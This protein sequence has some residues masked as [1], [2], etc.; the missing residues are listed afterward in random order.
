METPSTEYPI[1]YGC[2]DIPVMD[3]RTSRNA[4]LNIGQFDSSSQKKPLGF[5]S[6]PV[7]PAQLNRSISATVPVQW[8]HEI[9]PP[10]PPGPPPM[11]EPDIPP[12]LET[13]GFVGKSI[14]QK[15]EFRKNVIKG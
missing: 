5:V 11:S 6:A 13:E 14:L 12:V 2:A 1:N 4:N 7:P 3:P 10:L 9:K 8:N 15:V